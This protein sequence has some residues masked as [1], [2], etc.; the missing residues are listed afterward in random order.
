MRIWGK[1]M[2][3][4]I[5]IGSIIAVIILV[6]VSFTGVVGY[7]TTK[8]SFIAKASPLFS[9]RSKRAIDEESKEFTCDYVGKGEPSNILLPTRDN[10]I[11]LVQ[12]IIDCI[13]ILDD[14]TLNRFIDLIIYKIQQSNEFKNL[15]INEIITAIHFLR[16][17]QDSIVIQ[18]QNTNSMREIPFNRLFCRITLIHSN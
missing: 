12:K 11:A 16:E 13:R 17:N 1:N 7:Q 14:E 2:N 4:K 10:K 18:Y 6:L 15:N 5:L 8:S 3:K 9:V